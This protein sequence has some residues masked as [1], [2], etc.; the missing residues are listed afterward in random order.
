MLARLKDRTVDA[1][2]HALKRVLFVTSL[3]LERSVS[4]AHSIVQATITSI[5]VTVAG[6]S[7]SCYPTAQR[8]WWD[9]K[10]G[11][12]IVVWAAGDLDLSH[13]LSLALASVRSRSG[14]SRTGRP[15]YTVIV[16][17][18][19]SSNRLATLI[20]AWAKRKAEIA[21]RPTS[22]M[23]GHTTDRRA[24][25]DRVGVNEQRSALSRVCETLGLSNL[26]P[27]SAFG[28][29]GGA[30]SMPGK[31]HQD[32]DDSSSKDAQSGQSSP[33]R[34][35]PGRSSG[36]RRR[37]SLGGWS[38]HD[39]VGYGRDMLKG[40]RIGQMDSAGVGAIIP[41]VADTST[42]GGLSHA[43][44][45]IQ[46]YCLSHDLLLRAL[47]LIPSIMGEAQSTVEPPTTTFR[48]ARTHELSIAGEVRLADHPPSS[49]E[50]LSDLANQARQSLFS[51]VHDSLHLL[52]ALLPVLKAD[53]GRVIS[54]VPAAFRPSFCTVE[55]GKRGFRHK[56]P[57]SRTS[58]PAADN[59][60]FSV[61]R[62]AVLEM[63]SQ[64]R[65][66]LESDGIFVSLVHM[67]SAALISTDKVEGTPAGHEHHN[68][69]HHVSNTN[70]LLSAAKQS[71][72]SKVG[73]VA[74]T[75]VCRSHPLLYGVSTKSAVCSDTTLA[76]KA[77]LHG[78]SWQATSF[79][80]IHAGVFSTERRT[81]DDPK[82]CPTL[83]LDA[84]RSALVR[85]WPRKE[86]SVGLGPHL[87]RV[88][89][90]VPGHTIM[91]RWLASSVY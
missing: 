76:S 48:D 42:Q 20:G 17:M 65:E 3:L 66:M 57:Q 60:P 44:S 63:W 2:F 85:T 59:V 13:S 15:P 11:S 40:L 78:Q 35:S 79:E 22:V 41:V 39:V 18:P 49:H 5:A 37:L 52:A 90:C 88:W 21:A 58:Q 9:P 23:Q 68:A 51:D 50:K 14:T 47:I 91:A 84:V 4:Q 45:T 31:V 24:E 54:L 10:K 80:D 26:L 83:L 73:S 71:L 81:A 19:E 16:L 86:Y 12:A 87:E 32:D 56:D 77:T 64:L 62:K 34:Q 61:T 74:R 7:R 8:A 70:T 30:G 82:A 6:R 27:L 69:S 43:Q 46:A 53:G 1:A 89:E 29:D 38:A 72:F 33:S 55:T 25:D 36:K 67:T 75:I 28:A